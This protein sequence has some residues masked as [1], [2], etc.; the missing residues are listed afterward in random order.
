VTYVRPQSIV[1]RA[2]MISLG[3]DVLCCSVV[4]TCPYLSL[5]RAILAN[6]LTCWCFFYRSTRTRPSFPLLEFYALSCPRPELSLSLTWGVYRLL[7]SLVSP[8]MILAL[9]PALFSTLP[10][11]CSVSARSPARPFFVRSRARVPDVSEPIRMVITTILFRWRLDPA[12]LQ[13]F[14]TSFVCVY[15]KNA[16]VRVRG[17]VRYR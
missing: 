10:H 11:L 15:Q 17:A 4:P 14:R 6:V 8:V 1:V 5:L 3:I 9:G 13:L 2:R 16:F 7:V 12:P